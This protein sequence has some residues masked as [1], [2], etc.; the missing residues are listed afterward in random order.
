MNFKKINHPAPWRKTLAVLLTA[1]G[2]A[3]P[4]SQDARVEISKAATAGGALERQ[5]D[6]L[7]AK[8]AEELDTQMNRYLI[9]DTYDTNAAVVTTDNSQPGIKASVT[10]QLDNMQYPSYSYP[11]PDDDEDAR[12]QIARWLNSALSTYPNLCTLYTHCTYDCINRDNKKYLFDITV[13]SPV[14]AGQIIDVTSSYKTK[15]REL[16]AVPAQ[17]KTMTD[18]EKILYVHDR[19]A[20]NALYA[21][22]ADHLQH[23]AQAVLNDGTGVCQSY[24]YTFNLAMAELNIDSLFLASESHAWNAVRLGGKWYYVDVTWDDPKGSLCQVNHDYLLA[25]PS[26]FASDHTLLPEYNKIYGSIL[27]QMGNAYDKFFPKTESIYTDEPSGWQDSVPKNRVFSYLNGFWYYSNQL[28]VYMWDGHSDE[29]TKMTDIPSG[30][31]SSGYALGICTAVYGNDLYYSSP[32]GIFR[33]QANGDD[34]LLVNEGIA[35]M[36]LR[37]STLYYTIRNEGTTLHTYELATS[38]P[39]TPPVATYDPSSTEEPIINPH[40]VVP[41][42]VPTPTATAPAKPTMDPEPT[43][44]PNPSVT[45][46]PDTGTKPPAKPAIKSLDNFAKGKVR[47]T[48]RAVA[49]TTGYQVSYA[50]N[51]KFKKAKKQSSKKL[52]T[53]ISKLKKKTYYIRVRAYRKDDGGKVYSKWSAVKKIKIKKGL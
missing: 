2:L 29:G 25:A 39:T 26:A 28:G 51:K 53:V 13:Y 10:F 38:S 46:E 49:K 40:P 32:E 19:L 6:A 16:T 17:N 18:A 21:D 31:D 47:V 4:T 7:G 30:F 14:T 15:L 44:S 42:A 45:P 36:T 8:F 5:Y 43:T 48:I 23:T 3:L 27:R 50:T 22:P 33:Y 20:E 35:A 11:L 12:E 9:H 37:G 34:T 41:T 24:A 1:T 52:K